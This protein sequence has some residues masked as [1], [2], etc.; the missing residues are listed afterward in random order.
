MSWA[1]SWRCWG[2]S[3]RISC[4]AGQAVDELVDVLG[5]VGEELPVLVHELL[6]LVGRVLAPSVRGQQL[7]EVGQHVLGAG[8]RLLRLRAVALQ[9]FSHPGE[10]LVEH[11]ALQH[12]ADLVVRR[13][14]LRGA[15]VVVGQLAHGPRGVP[16]EIAES[17]LA[18]PGVV[19]GI[20]EERVGL[21]LDRP[22]E[23]LPDLVERAGQ[24]A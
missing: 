19:G 9:R 12:L 2:D 1:S 10:L 3:E 15:P 14:R 21:G 24:I 11:L 22:V 8:H 13:L 17:L 5:L 4:P 6:E 16:R 18:Q 7:V 20:G 23:Q